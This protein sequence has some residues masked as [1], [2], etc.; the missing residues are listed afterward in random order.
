VVLGYDLGGG[1]RAGGR[2]VLM[3]GRPYEI[4]CAT[5]AC[6]SASPGMMN[7]PYVHRGRFPSFSRL[8]V[9]F[10]KKWRFYSGAWI[11]ATFEWFNAL[12][13]RELD[14]PLLTPGG[15]TFTGRSPLTL[16]SVGID[17]GYRASAYVSGPVCS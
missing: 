16:P 12:L 7:A 15:I 4:G 3:S 5:P 17:G 1:F 10:E 9:R 11:A 14:T 8:D 2:Y 13:A 6:T